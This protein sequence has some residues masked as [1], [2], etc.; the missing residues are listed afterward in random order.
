MVYLATLDIPLDKLDTYPGN[1][2]QGNVSVIR[3]SLK[4][5]Q[6]YRA[7]VVQADDPEHPEN[8]GTV[9][10]GNHTLMAARELGWET[11]RA[12]LLHVNDE[13]A[14]RIVLVDNRAA[15]LGSYDDR[16][17]AELLAETDD[18]SGTGYD[19]QD[20]EALTKEF[21]V[22]DLDDLAAEVGEP[23]TDDGWPSI[24]MRVPHTVKAAWNAHLSTHSDDAAQAMASLL[25]VEAY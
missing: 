1:P 5:N 25:G 13:Q 23:N 9:L 8:G 18:L 2:R 20:L 22:P 10:A 7:I 17:L 12:D 24:T 11:I 4:H 19:E 3:D 6:Q 21:E 15:D 16:A 14:R